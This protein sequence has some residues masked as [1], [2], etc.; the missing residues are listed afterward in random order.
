[1]R[2]SRLLITIVLLQVLSLHSHAQSDFLKFQHLQTAAGLSQSNV[3]SIIQDSRGFMWFGTRDGL[4]K[5]DGYTFTVYKND[6]RNPNSIS[7]NYIAGIKEGAD[8]NIWIATWGGGLNKYDRKKNKFTCYKHDPN[9]SNSLPGDFIN[10]VIE[11]DKGNIWIGT[12]ANGLCV[13]DPK[14][15]TF[16]R[17]LHSA[18]DSK[19]LSD[20]FIRIIYQ[21]K[22]HR[23]WIGTTHGG[24]NLFDPETH[25]FIQYKHD[26]NLA[27]SLSY[28]E[29]YALFEDSQDRLWIGTNGGGLNLFNT[30]RKE[31]THFKNDPRNSNSLPKDEVYSIVE[32][33]NHNIWIGTENGGLSIYNPGKS[34]FENYIHDEIDNT[35]LSNNSIY[36][37]CRD[38]KGN[39][40]IGSFSGGVDFVNSDNHFTHYKHN[41][42]KT[43]LSS[44]LVLCI[45][46]D[47]KKNIWVSTDGGGLN[48][49][50]AATGN[51]THFV[52]DESNPNT[53][54]GNYV[55]NL[56]ED[57]NHNLWI[58]TWGNGVSVYNPATKKFKHFKNIPSDTTSLSN[59]NGW[60][61]YEDKDKNMW[62][63]T[64]GGGL[65]LYMPATHSFRRYTYNDSNPAGISSN[66][67]HSIFDDG[68]GNLWI[69]TDGGGL[70]VF[71]KKT[72][73]FSHYIHDNKKN[74]LASNSVG[75]I[76][77]DRNGIFW[78]ATESGL[79]RFDKRLN[80]FTN[81]ST[82]D[83][84]PNNVIFGIIEEQNNLW[85]STNKGI[86][87]FTP[88]TKIFKNFTVVDGLQGNEFKE[89]AFCRS[90]S[91]AF[92]F[93]G[94][95]GFNIF[96]P[97]K[98]NQASFDPPLVF[99]NFRIFN[100]SVQI[101]SDKNTSSPLKEDIAETRS[102]SIPYES[103]VIEF[104]F[105]A[106]NYTTNEKRQYAYMLDGFDKTWNEVGEKRTATYTNLPPAFYVFKVKTLNNEGQWSSHIASIDLHIVPPFWLTW[107]FKILSVFTIIGSCIFL[108]RLR[109]KNIK[110]QKTALE[111]QVKER[112]QQ[113]ILL[114]DEERK[115]RKDAEDARAEA[116]KANR[117]KSIFLAT[118]SHE[119][120]TPMNGVLG[121]TAL[122][123]ET[124][125]TEEQHNYAETIKHCGETLLT[126]IND[127]LDFSKIESGNME[128]E[129]K[130][131]DLRT[132][133]EEVLD[134]FAGKAAS[135][136][137]DLVYQID[138]NVP[139]QII[140]DG[141]RLRQILMNLVGNAI[142]FTHKGEIFVG[143][144]LLDKIGNDKIIL[145][146]EIRDTGI[147]IPAEKMHRL[148][149]SFS[150]V[151]SSTT[152]K[153]GGTGLGLA[154]CE[155]L[156]ALMNGTIKVNSEVN[157]GTVFN[158]TIQTA[159]SIQ[160]IR[161]YLYQ[162]LI[163]LE[164]KKILIV[165]DN[166]TNRQILEG[167]LLQWKLT[168]VSASSG[169]EA[170]AILDKDPMFDLL[171]SD[172]HMPGMDG[173][174]LAQHI[175]KRSLHFPII[176]LSSVGDES[177]K[178]NPGLFYS[179]LT[180]PIKQ[181]SLSKHILR[182]LKNQPENYTGEITN[183]G[184]QKLDKVFA[185]THP[186][187]IL[188][189][190]DDVLNQKLAMIVLGKL[191][192][193]PEIASNGKI[194]TDM[195]A[196]KHY[197]IIFMDIQM[198]GMD[199]LQA[200]K[201]IREGQNGQP[202]IIAMTANALIE[203]REMCMNA[204]MNDYISKPITFDGL[205]LVLEKWSTEKKN[206]E[207]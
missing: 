81:Y 174:L 75:Y 88:L 184:K 112:T 44:N 86:S 5:Y 100:K 110:E 135:V 191:G 166:A 193:F 90:S 129:S 196:A 11:D 101:T 87:R 63:G 39:M 96:Y 177:G 94:N 24:L 46:E 173:V 21:D 163:G 109:I 198:P 169:K 197:D 43:S 153:Y 34:I 19:S 165:D 139:S 206:R 14:K 73:Q 103:S 54:C 95:N 136:G 66:K 161:N 205:M 102:L 155:K 37:I 134:I 167:Q 32:D 92:Y 115:A 15:N 199:G 76:V 12:E 52:H 145:G 172:M 164:G 91:G 72:K 45:F 85:I 152:R 55:L 176:V 70:N 188:L 181:N 140:G 179:V 189:A 125:L 6:P 158:F 200:T 67:I 9:N 57:S 56:T 1:M 171:L 97:E 60:I 51:F 175:R 17:Y 185:N 65:N 93:G 143:V 187:K 26:E 8:G 31:F 42:N 18:G 156:I 154:I 83:G 74:S 29:V 59:N 202:V 180:K 207:N 64:Y 116:E 107:W 40:W 50:N 33:K 77:K 10:T 35:S 113:L 69:G 4:N 160:G 194:V 201:A 38:T 186:L 141:L 80:Q 124:S 183:P 22:S 106:L 47:S 16:T 41:S 130:D 126:V 144:Q 98:I 105:A 190:E 104:E 195:A 89:K 192:Y 123:S 111:V 117:A 3:L 79:S 28:N 203:D 68:E 122:L 150:Q 58:G 49:F 147:G 142:K 121:M 13:F 162:N 170:L 118:M 128:L 168:P 99:T 132:C 62:I 30:T 182:A 157:A 133:I 119:I 159:P 25:S 61:L 27:T 151:D 48:L 82:I 36:S 178:Q 148:F 78:I 2:F 84:L 138:H 120:R 7:N 71:N 53:I 20:D 146:F 108:Y 204:G 127:V 137:L 23:V 149:K 114:T 131:F